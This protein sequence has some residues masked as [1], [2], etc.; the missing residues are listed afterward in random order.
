MEVYEFESK[1]RELLAQLATGQ[2]YLVTTIVV[3]K[4]KRQ[5]ADAVK[6]ALS[7]KFPRDVL[8]DIRESSGR[9]AWIVTIS[10]P[11]D[12]LTACLYWALTSHEMEMKNYRFG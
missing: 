5:S 1:M 8:I 4:Q 9:F 10:G 6:W 11:F 7:E 12:S 3:E 2:R